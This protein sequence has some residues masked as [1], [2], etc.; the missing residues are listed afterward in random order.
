MPKKSF[1][2]SVQEDFGDGA[3]WTITSKHL[4]GL[5]LGG[6]NLQVLRDDLPAA[7]KLLFKANYDMDVEVTM[8]VD[9]P[10]QEADHGS[11]QYAALPKAA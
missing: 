7:I 2:I 6:K 9:G 5:F 11:T 4:P 3:Y 1:L 10:E 8:L